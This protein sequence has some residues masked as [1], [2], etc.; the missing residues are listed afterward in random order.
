MTDEQR[1]LFCNN[2]AWNNFKTRIWFIKKDGR[3][4]CAFVGFDNGWAQGGLNAK[5]LAFDWVAGFSEKWEPGKESKTV[6]GNSSQIVLETCAT[7]DEA[8][9][10][11]KTINE[12]S[13]TYAKILIADRSGASVIIGARDGRI[14]IQKMRQTRGFG[15]G[16]SII[17]RMFGQNPEPSIKNAACI[18]KEVMQKGLYA[19][20]Y[21]NIFN[22]KNGDIHIF[23][24][25]EADG[26]IRLNLDQEL[27]KGDHYYDIPYLSA[28]FGKK[29]MPL[30]Q[31]M[32]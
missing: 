12:K 5:G 29:A 21:S 4:G 28:Q 26:S 23:N 3:Y 15:Y 30:L 31:N 2:E 25:P 22:L 9:A 16:E 24:V 20:K 32:K 27:Q 7:V 13:F 10:F 18:L 11:Y 14:D 17:Y 8:I 19:T 6:E 1:T